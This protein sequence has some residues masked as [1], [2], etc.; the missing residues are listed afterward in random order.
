MGSISLISPI[1]KPKP[2][3]IQLKIPWAPSPSSPR[4]FI[5]RSLGLHLHQAHV[6][7][8]PS[9]PCPFI[10][11][12]LGLHLH[13]AHVHSLKKLK[14]KSTSLQLHHKPKPSAWSLKPQHMQNKQPR[15]H[16][17]ALQW[18]PIK[19][20]HENS[21]YTT[22]YGSPKGDVQHTKT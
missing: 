2:T 14:A 12:S 3:S 1:H 10:K 18:D 8:S 16:S 7:P 4:P 13:Q 21:F 9:S 6:A 5:N 22:A 19:H 11:R 15:N 17:L 20:L